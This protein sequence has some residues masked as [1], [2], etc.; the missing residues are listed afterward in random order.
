MCWKAAPAPSG[1]ALSIIAAATLRGDWAYLKGIASLR[2][3]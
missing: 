1:T 2:S 3:Q